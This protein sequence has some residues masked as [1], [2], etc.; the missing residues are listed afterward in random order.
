VLALSFL[1][2][3]SGKLESESDFRPY[4]VSWAMKNCGTKKA[5][6]CDIAA[7]F[8]EDGF[9]GEDY[10]YGLYHVKDNEKRIVYV[11]VAARKPHE[12]TVVSDEL[13]RQEK[14]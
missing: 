2:A 9:D 8:A 14:S 12:A 13:A 1:S 11:K 3:C 10:V 7:G 5:Y 4:L 6:Q